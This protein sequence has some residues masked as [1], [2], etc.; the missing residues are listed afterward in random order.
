VDDQFGTHTLI[1]LADGP[2]AFLAELDAG[3][4]PARVIRAAGAPAQLAELIR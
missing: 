1:S 2:Q 3:P 4:H